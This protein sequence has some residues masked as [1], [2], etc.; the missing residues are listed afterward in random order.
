MIQ[1]N[2]TKCLSNIPQIEI[3]KMVALAKRDSVEMD[4]ATRGLLTEAEPRD[5]SKQIDLGTSSRSDLEALGRDLKTAESNATTFESRYFPLVKAERDKV[6]HDAS[7]LEGKTNM[8]AKF[9]AMIDEQHADM[10]SLISR[11]SAARL[12]YYAAYEKCVALLVREFGF[13]KVVNG[14]IIFRFQPTADSYNDA[15]AKMAAAASRLK[16]LDAE[17]TTLKQ[18]QLDRWKNLVS[19]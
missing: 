8:L 10:K 6:E 15:A 4:I 7:V 3:L 19:R 11:I 2:W 12:E 5:L 17:R 18:P 16:E 9:M 14:Q 1:N 13:Y